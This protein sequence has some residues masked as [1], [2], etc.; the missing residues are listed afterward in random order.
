MHD[1]IIAH[2]YR[3]FC[4]ATMRKLTSILGSHFEH[5]AASARSISLLT[6]LGVGPAVQGTDCPE[7][8]RILRGR[9]SGYSPAFSTTCFTVFDLLPRK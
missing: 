3:A 9:Q 6:L 4:D 1:F 7:I 8:R 2:L 5:N